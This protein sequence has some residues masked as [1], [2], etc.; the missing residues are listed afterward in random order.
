MAG[1]HDFL[2]AEDFRLAA[3]RRLPKPLYD[4]IEG[5]ADDEVTLLRNTS[6]FDRYTLVPQYLRDVRALQTR[7]TV[8]GCDLAM[9]LI[10]SPTGMSRM[11]HSDGE[12]G[13]ARAAAAAGV[14]YSLSTM[15]SASIEAVAAAGDGPKIYQ[16]YLLADD[17]LNLASID[18]ARAAG[19]NAIC[20][21]VDT[22]VA[23][24]RE[25]DLRSGL[26]IPPKL[27]L[28]SLLHFAS[29]PSWVFDY[30]AG[31]KF[32]LPNVRD[33]AG[34]AADL[35]TLAAFFASKMERYISWDRVARL[36]EHWGGPFA[37]K[38]LQTPEDAA[39]GVRAGVSAV[40]VSNH[41]GRQLDGGAAT[42]DLLPQIVDAVGDRAEVILDGGVRRGTHILKA[43]A[44][45]ARAVMMGR[46]YVYS[47]AAAGEDGV[48]RFLQLIGEEFARDLAL[49][50]CQSVDDVSRRHIRMAADAPDFLN[51][52]PMPRA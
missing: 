43:L 32:S 14:G 52:R 34:G 36:A 26:T 5:G 6:A 25:R 23:G 22:I 47:L 24:N 45:G 10:L 42:I 16:L 15:G 44:M 9:P 49:L 40:I 31:G 7:R 18:R 35:T 38:G 17:A 33:P 1:R 2:N 41:G 50:G 3:K 8:L 4:Y 19:F 12:C 11:F 48:A 46:P 20:L 51:P 37:V 29:R 21:T 39:E 28:A 13:V 27:T 30:F